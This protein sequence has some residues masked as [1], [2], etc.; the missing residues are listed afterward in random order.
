VPARKRVIA[1]FVDTRIT[2][3]KWGGLGAAV[4]ENMVALLRKNAELIKHCCNQLPPAT[5]PALFTI[6]QDGTPKLSN[7]S[8]V[9]DKHT[10]SN[11]DSTKVI[12]AFHHPREKLAAIH[13]P[14]FFPRWSCEPEW[15][16]VCMGLCPSRP[17]PRSSRDQDDQGR[18]IRPSLR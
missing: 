4:F 7:A 12:D 2:T 6:S 9:S 17:S 15:M 1:K 3:E 18:W 14:I 8:L 11:L 5:T 10:R 16:P 13:K